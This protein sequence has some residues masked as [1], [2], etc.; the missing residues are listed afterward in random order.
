MIYDIYN[1]NF[2]VSV[3]WQLVL[4]QIWVSV[5]RVHNK[6]SM[7]ARTDSNFEW[8]VMSCKNRTNT[9]IEYDLD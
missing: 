5:G 4:K 1:E 8:I 6:L 7:T 2:R 3:L 9:Y